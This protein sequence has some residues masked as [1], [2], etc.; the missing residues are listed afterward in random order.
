MNFGIFDFENTKN[1]SAGTPVRTS[2]AWRPFSFRFH[3]NQLLS[4][5]KNAS[6]KNQ[7][8]RNKKVRKL[9]ALF[10][11]KKAGYLRALCSQI[12]GKNN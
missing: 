12:P 1:G 7:D 10:D 3:T 4:Q 6:P 11:N 8:W 9:S 2:G 5:I